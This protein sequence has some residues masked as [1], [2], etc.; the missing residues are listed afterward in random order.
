MYI[1]IFHYILD[2]YKAL[3]SSIEA[4]TL[5]SILHKVYIVLKR[6]WA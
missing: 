5:V 1:Y 2:V 4:K 3:E 6:S